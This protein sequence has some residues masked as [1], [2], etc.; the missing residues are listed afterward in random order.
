MKS[1][2]GTII[3]F[4]HPKITPVF[5]QEEKKP[6]SETDISSFSCSQRNG[7]YA[8]SGVL[9]L[10]TDACRLHHFSPKNAYYVPDTVLSVGDTSVNKTDKLF[11]L[12]GACILVGEYRQ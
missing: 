4:L 2:W 7:Y 11:P 6:V 5:R 9:R 10:C 1:K 8:C 12:S 3:Y